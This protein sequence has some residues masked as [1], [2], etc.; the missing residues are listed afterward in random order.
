MLSH[1]GIEKDRVFE[2]SD[3]YLCDR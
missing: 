2:S 1:D 3:V